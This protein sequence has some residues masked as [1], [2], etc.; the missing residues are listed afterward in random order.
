MRSLNLKDTFSWT[1]IWSC[2]LK[3]S[4]EG[5][6]VHHISSTII[7]P[8]FILGAIPGLCSSMVSYQSSLFT[9]I[10]GKKTSKYPKWFNLTIAKLQSRLYVANLRKL[11]GCLDHKTPPCLHSSVQVMSS[12]K[13]VRLKHNQ[14]CHPHGVFFLCCFWNPGTSLLKQKSLLKGCFFS[15]PEIHHHCGPSW[16]ICPFVC[17]E[18]QNEVLT[19]EASCFN[20]LNSWSFAMKKLFMFD[21]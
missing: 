13:E 11:G 7:H 4:L 1:R 2:P 3:K 21:P 9:G 12:L 15:L 20:G 6:V 5:R 16:E 18:S 8:Q 19:Q 10:M 14:S 17:Q